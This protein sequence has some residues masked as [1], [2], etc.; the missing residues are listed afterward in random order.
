MRQPEKY[1]GSPHSTLTT[2]ASSLSATLAAALFLFGCSG[3]PHP[4]PGD[5]TFVIESMPANLDPRIGTDFASE[6]LDGLLFDSLVQRDAQMN[7]APDLAASWEQPDPTT[8]VFH[9]RH[10]VRFHDGRA[11]TSADVKFTFDSIISGAITTSKRGAFKSVTAIETPD[12]YTVIVRMSSI[13][14][15]FLWDI[16]RPAVGIVPQGAGTGFAQHPIGTGPF[17]FES[18]AQDDNVVFARNPDYFGGAPQINEVHFRIVPDAI[19]RALELRKGTADLEM[20]S[21][22]PDMV[23]VLARNSGIAVTEEPGTNYQYLAFNFDN[24]VLA[25]REVRQALAYATDRASIVQYLLR[26]QARL[27][28]GLLPPGNWA[29]APNLPTYPYDPARAEQLLDAAGFP[30]RANMGGIRL[31]LTLKTSTEESARLLGEVL[32]EQW[33]KVGV[34][35]ELRT[36]EFGTLYS[37]ITQGNFE[38]YTLRWIGV[39]NDP[40]VF[41]FAFESDHMPPAGANRG[42]YR[43][44]Q[45]D[46]LVA[47]ASAE[48][49]IEKRKALYIQV[50][51]IIAEDLPYISLW[52]TDNICVH[53]TRI[54]G[55]EL[56]PAGNYDFLCAIRAN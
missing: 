22:S 2:L 55:I 16:S 39:N 52:F 46:A 37:D 10:D 51:R 54:T 41:Q 27:A 56:S 11:L 35:L 12:P 33:R 29:A 43:N 36:L 38:M 6:R 18:S 13:S 8:Y 26:G 19:V 30:R 24:S 32:R 47:Q 1:R 7:V 40:S 45:L 44:P 50:Q 20:T 3:A 9:L 14:T 5:V 48:P 4:A 15:S 25:H 17:R 49:D 31:Q 21:L 34:D 53:R 42:H 28:D 23:P